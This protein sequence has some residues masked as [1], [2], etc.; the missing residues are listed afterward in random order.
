MDIATSKFTEDI[1]L[2]NYRNS[3]V[4][5]FNVLVGRRSAA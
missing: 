3:F 5:L 4:D 2:D 1:F